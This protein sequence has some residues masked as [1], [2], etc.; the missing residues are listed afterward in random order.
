MSAPPQVPRCRCPSPPRAAPPVGDR[1]LRSGQDDQVGVAGKR[2]AR[3]D[4]QHGHIRLGDQRIEVVE[5][6]DARQP[7]DGDADRLPTRCCRTISIENDGVLGRQ[8]RAGSNHGT[9]PKLA[10]PVR[11]LMIASPSSNRLGSPRTC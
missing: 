11:S 1:R 8:S 5:V 7:R 3:R 2:V 4:E 6:G 9:T 10:R